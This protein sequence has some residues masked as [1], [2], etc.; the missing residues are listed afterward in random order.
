MTYSRLIIGDANIVRFWQAS[1][2]AAL[3]GPQLVGVPLKA[4]SCLDTYESALA[5]VTEEFDLVL[6]SVLTS[7][8]LDEIT[9]VDVRNS[10]LNVFEATIKRL[11]A[12]AKRNKKVEVRFEQY[13]FFA[14]FFFVP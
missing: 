9:S 7:L 3:S 8:L 11:S 12:V 6:V 10:S 14:K 13:Y 5:S 2:T 1:Q 4:V